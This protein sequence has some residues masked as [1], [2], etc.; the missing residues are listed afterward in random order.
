MIK[1]QN[2]V[3]QREIITI[4]NQEPPDP[5]AYAD[6]VTAYWK[7]FSADLPPSVAPQFCSDLQDWATLRNQRRCGFRRKLFGK[8]AQLHAPCGGSG[9]GL[10]FARHDLHRAELVNRCGFNVSALAHFG[11]RLACDGAAFRW[12]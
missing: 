11:R 3:T 9:T 6:F 8:R 5:H 2:W 10:E 12:K 1:I 7:G 4:L